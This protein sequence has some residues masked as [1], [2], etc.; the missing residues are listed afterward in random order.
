MAQHFARPPSSDVSPAD[1]QAA[2]KL[3]GRLINATGSKGK[4]PSVDHRAA[5][6]R[7]QALFGDGLTAA[8]KDAGRSGRS[9]FFARCI[10]RFWRAF[11]PQKR[12]LKT[13]ALCKKEDNR[14]AGR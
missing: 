10:D 12:Y 13:E 9:A 2:A 7:Y 11:R 14:A 4:A 6:G 1:R 5:D 3:V 8:L